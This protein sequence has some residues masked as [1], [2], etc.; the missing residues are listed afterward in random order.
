MTPAD[1]P[2]FV[3]IIVGLAALK[4]GKPLTDEGVVLFWSAMQ[5]WSIEEFRAAANHLAKSVEFMPNPYHFEQLRKASEPT[6]GEAWAQVRG[7]LKHIGPH[8]RV[9]ISPRIDR[10]VA[11]MGGYHALA[12]SN[13]DAMPFR[14][15]RFAELWEEMGEADEIRAALPSVARITGPASISNLLSRQVSNNGKTPGALA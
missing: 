13:S 14:E 10:V 3:K 7:K 9:S 5:D 15:K 11:A 1:K 8:D 12:M 6:P 2:E 4:P